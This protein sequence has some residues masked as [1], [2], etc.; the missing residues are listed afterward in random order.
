MKHRGFG[1]IQAMMIM[2]LIS[3]MMLGVLKYAS[4]SA[5]HTRDTYVREQ[6]ELFLNSS[7]EKTLLAI[8]AY[9][10]ATHGDCVASYSDTKD[11]RGVTYNADVNITSYYLLEGSDDAS[12]CGSLTKAITSEETHG[13]V[14]LELTITATVDGVETIRLIRRTLQ[15]P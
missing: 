4:I 12:Y 9:D 11:K 8:S 10:R 2:L 13:M 6:A 7:I 15:R 5:K 14:M 3:G 1:L